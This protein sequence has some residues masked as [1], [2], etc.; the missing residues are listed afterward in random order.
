ME[1]RDNSS[2]SIDADTLRMWDTKRVQF[3]DRFPVARLPRTEYDGLTDVAATYYVEQASSILGEPAKFFI[4]GS[5][6]DVIF[7]TSE[8]QVSASLCC[9]V[10]GTVDGIPLAVPIAFNQELQYIPTDAQRVVIDQQT[11]PTSTKSREPD[12]EIPCKKRKC[13]VPGT[14][15]AYTIFSRAY[16]KGVVKRDKGEFGTTSR[17]MSDQWN[18]MDAQQKQP[19]YDEYQRLKEMYEKAQKGEQSIQEDEDDE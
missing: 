7:L 13:D 3:D 10:A 14:P 9:K 11:K 12:R 8:R 15:N 2:V 17:A 18:R 4:D 16:F 1:T 6:P 5:N 19:Y